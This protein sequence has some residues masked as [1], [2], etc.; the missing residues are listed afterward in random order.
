MGIIV[1]KDWHLRVNE[2]L[3]GKEYYCG[4]DPRHGGFSW[5]KN[6]KKAVQFNSLDEAKGFTESH[7]P[8]SGDWGKGL[9]YID[10]DTKEV[11]ESVSS[12]D[13]HPETESERRNTEPIEA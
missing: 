7:W 5:G 11:V 13:V 8:S 10:T 9:E 1:R 3:I 6:A 12:V 2:K 4:I